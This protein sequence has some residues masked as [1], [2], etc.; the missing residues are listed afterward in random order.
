MK[1]KL[2]KQQ[3]EVMKLLWNSDEPLMASDIVKLHES[4]NINTVQA[5]LRVLIKA[6]AI[7][8][9]DIVHSGT[10]LSR[11]YRPLLSKDEYFSETYKDILGDAS[12][13]S[14]IA[15]FISIETDISELDRL[16]ELIDKR[17]AEIKGR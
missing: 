14:L 13:S 3:L 4:L 2:S 11:R 15:S 17:K 7:E 9:A 6:E 5:C 16:R 8:V 12:R 1:K 10:V